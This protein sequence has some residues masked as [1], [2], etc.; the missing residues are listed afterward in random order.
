MAF[1]G[2]N[3]TS[4]IGAM[5]PQALSLAVNGGAAT[6]VTHANAVLD[7]GLVRALLPEGLAR[8]VVRADGV[9]GSSEELAVSLR[10]QG[11]DGTVNTTL[12]ATLDDTT[13]TGAGEFEFDKV[14]VTK[15]PIGAALSLSVAYTAGTPNDPDITLALQLY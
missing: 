15:I 7:V 3:V 14:D 4:Y 12:L 10:W 11:A 13:V 2:I 9:Y 1:Q 6:V 5:S 8:L